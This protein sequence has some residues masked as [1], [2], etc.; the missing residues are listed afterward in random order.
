[1]NTETE[2]NI[3]KSANLTRGYCRVTGYG[4][5][6][7]FKSC[8]ED[9]DYKM[10]RYPIKD[11]PI[12]GFSEIKDNDK[13]IFTNSSAILS[14]EIFTAAHEIGHHILHLNKGCKELVDMGNFD[15]N[16]QHEIEANYFAACLLMP[17][18]EVQKFIRFELNDKSI[19]E[20]NGLDIAMFQAA[21]NVSFNMVLNRLNKLKIIGQKDITRF[22]D[23]KSRLSVSRLLQI[24]YGSN[25]LCQPSNVKQ[26]PAQFMEWV[27]YNYREKLIPKSTLEKAFSYFGTTPTDIKQKDDEFK[28]DNKSLDELIKGLNE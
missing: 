25:T 4:F 8:C 28:D 16:N 3:E 9:L 1:L 13:I 23:S 24:V 11:N 10:I 21:F 27:I 20:W 6:D 12:L 22:Q 26:V 15:S 17:K 7:I 18:E 5:H 19:N 2:I 14:R